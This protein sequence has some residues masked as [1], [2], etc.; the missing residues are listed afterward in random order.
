MLLAI[1]FLFFSFFSFFFHSLS[2]WRNLHLI[3]KCICTHLLN[4]RNLFWSK[5]HSTA[6]YWPIKCLLIVLPSRVLGRNKLM[7][8]I[9][10]RV[11]Q[12]IF[13][14]YEPIATVCLKYNK[15]CFCGCLFPEEVQCGALMPC[16]F[17]YS[18]YC[19]YLGSKLCF[20]F[21]YLFR[22]PHRNGTA[23]YH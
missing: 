20:L 3:W 23:Y 8:R 7:E 13:I 22:L 14:W 15:L 18:L 19:I 4:P 11:F 6:F 9:M 10:K 2:C 21:G 16:I 17:Y 12:A 1:M 5:A